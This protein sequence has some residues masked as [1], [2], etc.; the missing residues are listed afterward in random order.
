MRNQYLL[1]LGS[2]L[3]ATTALTATAQAGTI[4]NYS[5]QLTAGGLKPTSAFTSVKMGAQLFGG[6]GYTSSTTIGPQYVFA[7]LSNNY[8]SGL[9]PKVMFY[10]SGATFASTAL[11][12]NSASNLTLIST[13]TQTSGTI[14]TTSAGVGASCVIGILTTQIQITNC[15]TGKSS[16]SFSGIALS[17]LIY[18]SASSLATVGTTIALSGAV[19]EQANGSNTYETIA[20]TTVITSQNMVTITTSSS[21]ATVQLGA[22]TTG[23]TSVTQTVSG[24]ASAGLTV[25]LTQIQFT[26]TGSLYSNLTGTGAVSNMVGNL[27]ITVTSTALAD[28]AVS[29]VRFVLGSGATVTNTTLTSTASWTSTQLA[30]SLIYND[31]DKATNLIQVEY[32]GTTALTNAAAGT[33]AGTFAIGGTINGTALG[34]IAPATSA[35]SR[36]GFSVQVNSVQSS[37]NTVVTSYIRVTNGG[38]AAGAPIIT[39][40]NASS[41]AVMGTYTAASVNGLATLQLTAKDIETGAGITAASTVPSYDLVITGSLASGY[42]QHVTGNPGNLFVDF[43]GRRSGAVSP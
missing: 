29:N 5:A 17:G 9:G 7:N 42:V 21:S 12:T 41:G 11:G 39:V 3:L 38:T 26:S 35:V 14:N 34:G 32:N 33:T 30:G 13:L 2:V 20:S 10:P 43:S 27:G 25:V 40:Y 6:T 23:Y 4:H 24:N 1:G 37:L 36:A 22:G 31:T 19:V 16:A 15:L 18:Q 8:T 28:P